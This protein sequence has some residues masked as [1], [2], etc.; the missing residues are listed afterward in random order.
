MANC[1]HCGAELLDNAEF[2]TNCGASCKEDAQSGSQNPQSNPYYSSGQNQQNTSYTPPVYHAYNDVPP[3]K[4]SR[5][6]VTG[7]WEYLLYFVLMGIPVVGLV[8]FIIWACGASEKQN[9]INFSRAYLLYMAISL[10]LALLFGLIF[11]VIFAGV[12]TNV[13]TEFDG[14]YGTP[15]YDEYDQRSADDDFFANGG[16]CLPEYGIAPLFSRI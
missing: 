6:S 4:E 8:V 9:R 2:C 7:M 14:Y 13:V 1:R 12:I 3:P 15:F 10:V 11:G 5:Y 16:L